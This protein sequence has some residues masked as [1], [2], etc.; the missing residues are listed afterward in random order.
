MTG[1][2]GAG[3]ATGTGGGTAGTEGVEEEEEEEEGHRTSFVWTYTILF[4]FYVCC[5]ISE[6]IL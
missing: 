4:L 6:T 1:T 3:T 5:S 2:E